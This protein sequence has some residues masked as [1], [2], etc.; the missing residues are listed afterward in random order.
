MEM[1]FYVLLAVLVVGDVAVAHIINRQRLKLDVSTP[2]GKQRERTLRG[3][4]KLLLVYSLA[5]AIILMVIIKPY[6]VHGGAP[7]TAQQWREE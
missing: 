1:L 3:L 7:A 5:L 4:I 2:E 6:F